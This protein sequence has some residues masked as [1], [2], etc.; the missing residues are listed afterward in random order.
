MRTQ[1][2][3][4]SIEPANLILAGNPASSESC[5][6]KFDDRPCPNEGANSGINLIRSKETTNRGS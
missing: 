1:R 3:I 4:W 5:L 2:K 6:K